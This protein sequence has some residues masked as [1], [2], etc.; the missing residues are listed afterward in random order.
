MPGDIILHMCTKNYDQIMYSSQDMV[1]AM[2][3]Q[4]KE[5]WMGRRGCQIPVNLETSGFEAKFS[6]NSLMKNKMKKYMPKL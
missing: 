6:K 5:G 3:R 4:K 2:D 1:C